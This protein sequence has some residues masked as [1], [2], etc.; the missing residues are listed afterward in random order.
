MKNIRIFLFEKIFIFSGKIS[1]YLNRH[2]FVM[3]LLFV[4]FP[5]ASYFGNLV[6]PS[7]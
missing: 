7:K 5:L 6:P 2:V 4:L 1:V 3:Y